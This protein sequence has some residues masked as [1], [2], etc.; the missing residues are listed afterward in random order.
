M[1]GC[2]G[3]SFKG[4]S[5]A[6]EDSFV[7][8]RFG[9]ETNLTLCASGQSIYATGDRVI[10]ELD[11][12]PAY[13]TVRQSPMPVF[14]PC[15]KSSAR[16]IVRTV[17]EEDTRDYERKIGKEM[18]VKQFCRQRSAE[19]DLEMKVSKVD[20]SLDGKRAKVFFTAEGGSISAAWCA[21][22][23]ASSRPRYG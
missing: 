15:Q 21:T 9:E 10:V 4:L 13:G 5:T 12:G 16:S 8:V 22:C 1:S 19:L 20:F 23:R 14:K 18:A 17:T 3:C 7:G 11:S 6:V 2:A